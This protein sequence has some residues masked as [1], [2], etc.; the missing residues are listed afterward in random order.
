[1]EYWVKTR[2]P[3][4]LGERAGD[5][6]QIR[7]DSSW[8]FVPNIPLFHYSIIPDQWHRKL[9]LKDKSLQGV[10]EIPRRSISI[11]LFS[12]TIFSSL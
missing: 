5:L 11:S 7:N 4:K 3:R 9:P 12:V 10:V 8:P 2:L 1:V 6:R